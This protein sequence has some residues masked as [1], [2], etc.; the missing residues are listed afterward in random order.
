MI[1]K[2]IVVLLSIVSAINIVILCCN[3]NVVNLVHTSEVSPSGETSLDNKITFELPDNSILQ[4]SENRLSENKEGE[5]IEN[6]WELNEIDMI[7]NSVKGKW[8]IDKYRSFVP[9]S[10]YYLSLYH[11]NLKYNT[12]YLTKLIDRYVE[13]QSIAQNHIPDIQF[14]IKEDNDESVD[15]N[16]IFSESFQSP[17]SIIF[18]RNT[19]GDAYPDRVYRT[20]ITIDDDFKPTYPVIYLQFY[21]IDK[22]QNNED[23]I[24]LDESHIGHMIRPVTMIISSDKTVCLLVDGAFY[25][26]EKVH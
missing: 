24:D 18:S 4:I 23:N 2:K 26:L 6:R 21:V 8:C 1:S 20:A 10:I 13:K 16:Y 3:L 7:L 19:V 15:N 12:E 5:Y 22:E 11:Y 25:S 9:A 17:I 14:S